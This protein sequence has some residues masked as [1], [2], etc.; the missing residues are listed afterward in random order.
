MHHIVVHLLGIHAR[1][2]VSAT[3]GR[4]TIC[5]TRQFKVRLEAEVIVAAN[6]HGEV[7]RTFPIVAGDL[8]EH[9]HNHHLRTRITALRLEHYLLA[10][11]AFNIEFIRRQIVLS[12]TFG[13]R[14]IRTHELEG[15][16]D[17]KR[18]VQFVFHP[19]HFV[20]AGHKVLVFPR[21][22]QRRR[23]VVRTFH[24]AD[25]P[26][27]L[28]I[29]EVANA[30]VR[31]HFFH[32]LVVPER[33]GVVIAIREDDALFLAGFEVVSTEIAAG[34][35]LRTVMIVPVLRSHLNRY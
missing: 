34:I 32:F 31:S 17:L 29:T 18:G 11:L 35:T 7:N 9:L 4:H 2:A 16:A 25:I 33:E 20:C 15:L 28:Q 10:V 8:R 22:R 12:V 6:G 5:Q 13:T 30:Q 27:G 21:N 23:V 26:V 3:F 1:L 19:N 14:V 24:L